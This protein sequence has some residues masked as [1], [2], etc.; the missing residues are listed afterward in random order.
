MYVQNKL[1]VRTMKK[2]AETLDF[3]SST[4]L[5]LQ[6]KNHILERISQGEWK[7]DD[8]LPTEN[9]FKKEYDVSRATIRQGLD[10]IERGGTIE[11]RRGIGTVVS[12]KRIK[13]ELMKLTSFSEDMISRGLAPQS[14]TIDID[15]LVPSQE[16]CDSFGIPST[17]KVWCVKRLRLG[18]NQP[19]AV[20]DLYIPPELQLSARE[21]NEIQSYYKLLNDR[22]NLK[23]SHASETLTAV[24]ASK[25]EAAILHV[26][27][28]NPLLQVW[29]T[30]YSNEDQVIEVVRIVYRADRYEYHTQLYV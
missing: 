19:V 18:D 20:Q 3:K 24:A 10:E 27:E 13:P 16:V 11:R 29:R 28:G 17:G 22:F 4:P 5:Y 2:L 12:H 14:Q 25:V 21:L 6:F 1:L 15:F 9:E 8:R 26:A 7:Q 23:P 30:T